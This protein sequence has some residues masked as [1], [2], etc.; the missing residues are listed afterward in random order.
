[1]DGCGISQGQKQ[2]ILIARAIY[3]N[4]DYLFFDEATNALDSQNEKII[5]QNLSGVF[6]NRTVVV[7]AHRLS[8]IKAADHIIVL[9]N[10]Q[11]FEQGTHRELME[12]RGEYYR[13]VENQMEVLS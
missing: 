13:L 7:C 5:W 4:P 3:K 6:C 1:M 8:T 12:K 10:G 11:V 9:R 2:R